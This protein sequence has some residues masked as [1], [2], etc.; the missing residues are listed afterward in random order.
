MA[1]SKPLQSL[2]PQKIEIV[3][4]K[5]NTTVMLT[6]YAPSD[7]FSL[8]VWLLVNQSRHIIF[9]MKAEYISY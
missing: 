9:Q 8:I 6:P 5:G 4:L 3:P 2:F 1:C 7:A